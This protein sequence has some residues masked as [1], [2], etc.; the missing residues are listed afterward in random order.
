MYLESAVP[1]I[2]WIWTISSAL[3]ASLIFDTPSVKTCFFMAGCVIFKLVNCSISPDLGFKSSEQVS[4]DHIK[5]YIDL[6]IKYACVLN[7][8][9]FSHRTLCSARVQIFQA[10]TPTPLYT[11]PSYNTCNKNFP[12]FG[13]LVGFFFSHRSQK[14]WPFISASFGRGVKEGKFPIIPNCSY[15]SRHFGENHGEKL[16][17]KSKTIQ[18]DPAVVSSLNTSFRE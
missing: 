12:S 17:A 8:S 14:S 15:C 1:K 7:G 13:L 4:W 3:G 11:S 2:C 5:I 10:S 6:L 18:V 16:T 9:T